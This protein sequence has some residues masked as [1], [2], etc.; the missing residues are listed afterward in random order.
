MKAE[1]YFLDAPG[2][3]LAKP[4]YELPSPG[5]KEALVEVLACG[6]CHTDLA[7]ANG[8]VGTKHPLPLVLGHEVTGKVTAAGDDFVHLL[9]DNVVV[10]AVLPC[11]ECAFCQAG[12]GNACP[13]QKM[14]GN[15]IHGGFATHL[16]V[17]A[18]ALGGGTHGERA[19]LRDARRAKRTPWPRARLGRRIPAPPHL[20]VQRHCGRADPGLWSFGAGRDLGASR[21]HPRTGANPPLEPNGLR[22]HRPRHLGLSPQ[23]YPE[24]LKLVYAGKVVLGPFVERAPMSEIGR[25]LDEM[26]GDRLTHRM[27]L[28]PRA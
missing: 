6:L 23:R 4:E 26:A 27:I 25:L 15:D 14:P 19:R 20:R 3:A 2:E 21:L 10:P 5:P 17:P 12:R 24:I 9:G 11:G 1:A 28:D 8:S 16:V 22:R 7:F 18:G 13:K